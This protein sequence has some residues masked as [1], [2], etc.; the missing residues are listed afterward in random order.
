MP[1]ALRPPPRPAGR[2]AGDVPSNRAVTREGRADQ[3]RRAR[4]AA[5]V[6][7]AAFPEVE[8]LRIELSFADPSSISPASQV[9]MLYPPARA[10]FTYPC[11]HSDCD[12]EFELERAIRMA[13]S[14]ATHGTQGSLLCG[15]SRPGEG[16]SRRP[17]ELRL[18]YVITTRHHG[19]I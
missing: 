8:Q 1:I 9:H 12:G 18:A 2:P 6:L 11:P 16:G 4:A 10:F 3:L 13:V 14:D 19:A 5:Q 15:G 17:C 7:R